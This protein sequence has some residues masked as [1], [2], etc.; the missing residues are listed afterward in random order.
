MS[1]IFKCSKCE[2]ENVSIKIVT[3]LNWGER[4][5]KEGVF[6][7]NLKCICNRCGYLWYEE[8]SDTSNG[9]KNEN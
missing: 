8:P 5:I 7:K 3:G 6:P 2:S 9:D 4:A 1:R